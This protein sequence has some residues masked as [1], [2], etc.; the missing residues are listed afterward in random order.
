MFLFKFLES[1]YLDSFFKTGSLRVGTIYNFHDTVTHTAAR[2][3]TEEGKQK[4]IRHVLSPLKITQD[5]EE[6]IVSDFFRVRG[7]GTLTIDGISFIMPRTSDDAFIFCTS[8]VY[9]HSIFMKWHADSIK[10]N[11]CYAIINP[12][13]FFLEITKVIANSASEIINKN[14]VYTTDPILYDSEDASLH[15]SI[16]KEKEKY[17][18]QHENRSIWVPKLPPTKIHP[19][20]VSVPNARQYCIPLSYIENGKIKYY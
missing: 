15:P 4:I 11:A 2:A 9:S 7:D 5:S 10:N 8:R 14:I 19:F 16:T 1:Q 17:S 18:W 12:R 13:N 20:V 3:D 6:P